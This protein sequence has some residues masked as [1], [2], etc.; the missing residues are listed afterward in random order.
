[1]STLHIFSKPLS[2]YNTDQLV[3]LIQVTD[4]VLLLSDAC[5]AIRQFRQLSTHLLILADDAQSRGITI[6]EPD[7]SLNYDDF[8][9]LTLA[10]SHSIT[11]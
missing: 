4:Q 10:T 1:M 2:Y 9:A 11:W 3:N 7:H 6:S 5:F 8:V